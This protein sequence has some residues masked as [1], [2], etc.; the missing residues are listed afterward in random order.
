MNASRFPN[1]KPLHP[2]PVSR[3]AFVRGA[4][5]AATLSALPRLR[6]ALPAPA[7]AARVAFNTANLVA[8]FS[9][10]RFTRWNE[11]VQK[12]VAAMNERVWAEMCAEIA[13]AG[14]RAVE[15]WVA[16][17]DPP[18]MT[19]AR[20]AAFRRILD[21]HGLQPIGLGGPLTEETA[22]VCRLFGMP[23]CNGRGN[24][25]WDQSRALARLTGIRYF[26]ENHPEKSVTELVAAI[27]GGGPDIGLTID[28]GWLATQGLDAPA[29]IR[30]LPRELVRHVHI[31]DVRHAGKHETCP[32]GEGVV[33]FPG[34]FAAL[35]EIGYT[36]WYS[37]EDEPEDRN[38]MDIARAMREKIE[39]FLT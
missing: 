37:W 20:A 28:T 2:S 18:T 1:M 25:P 34:T 4:L 27:D 5:A 24:L 23:S 12:T 17:I 13:A 21:D 26:W 9:G 22:R 3:R 19:D 15:I 32:L 10:Y 39:G 38:P 35:R 7:G 11:Q 29:T 16:H 14:F 6:A 8:R 36:G 31:K 33:D 30:A